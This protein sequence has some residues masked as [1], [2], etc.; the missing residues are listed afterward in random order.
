MKKQKNKLQTANDYINVADIKDNILYTKDNHIISFI[1]LSTVSIST[2]S[3]TDIRILLRTLCS[4]FANLKSNM[5]FFKISKPIDISNLINDY[6]VMYKKSVDL[7]QKELLRGATL[8]LH[9]HTTN[10]S[11]L[12]NQHYMIVREK[13]KNIADLEKNVSNIVR[14]FANAKIETEVLNTEEIARLCNLFTNP[15]Y[16]NENMSLGMSLNEEISV[17]EEFIGGEDID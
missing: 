12:E 3:K 1:K 17:I 7:K 11:E 6:K 9:K 14:R 16:V 8:Y 13:A 15:S 2:M 10:K 4:E 5:R